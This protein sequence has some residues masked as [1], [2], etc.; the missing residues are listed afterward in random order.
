MVQG[1]RVSIEREE[2]RNVEGEKLG[3][4]LWYTCKCNKQSYSK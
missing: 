1:A 4:I 2:D 3:E